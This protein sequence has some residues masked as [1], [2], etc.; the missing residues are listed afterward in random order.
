METT[1]RH[2]SP[3]S[4][5]WCPCGGMGALP[6]ENDPGS[7]L[8]ERGRAFVHGAHADEYHRTSR[9]YHGLPD[10]FSTPV[11]ARAALSRLHGQFTPASRATP[12]WDRCKTAES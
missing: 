11:L 2:M 7:S 1:R 10:S 4:S 5:R 9:E 8:F 12:L 6:P 3:Q